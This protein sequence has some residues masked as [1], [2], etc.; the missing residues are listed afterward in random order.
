VIL[1]R[2]YQGRPEKIKTLTGEMIVDTHGWK[3]QYDWICNGD[4]VLVQ[5]V[6]D[7][8]RYPLEEVLGWMQ[9]IMA[10]TMDVRLP[11]IARPLPRW[12]RFC[13]ALHTHDAKRMEETGHPSHY[14]GYWFYNKW[15]VSKRMKCVMMAMMGFKPNE[16]PRV[17]LYDHPHRV[18]TPLLYFIT[19]MS[20]DKTMLFDA[21]LATVTS[22]RQQPLQI[23]CLHKMPECDVFY[24]LASIPPHLCMYGRWFEGRVWSVLPMGLNVMF[25]GVMDVIPVAMWRSFVGQVDCGIPDLIFNGRQW[26]FRLFRCPRNLQVWR[27]EP[28]IG[29]DYPDAVMGTLEGLEADYTV[30]RYYGPEHCDIL[31]LMEAWPVYQWRDKMMLIWWLMMRKT[32]QVDLTVQ[33]WR[34]MGVIIS[35]FVMRF[36]P[37]KCLPSLAPM[38]Q[39]EA[40]TDDMAIERDHAITYM[41]CEEV[42]A[43]KVVTAN[44]ALGWQMKAPKTGD[45]VRR[46]MPFAYHYVKGLGYDHIRADSRVEYVNEDHDKRIPW[47]T[48]KTAP[49]MC[50]IRDR[51][52]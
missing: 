21:T 38:Y 23:N 17:D 49:S 14:G 7:I 15:R 29:Q 28:R 52:M 45:V 47:V 25:P 3:A 32:H 39:R 19:A 30:P 42:K 12:V 20:G 6:S 35:P 48:P 27:D 4:L 8:T 16:V 41:Y 40:F 44:C 5:M 46:S 43:Y 34:E 1:F 50:W 37:V 24:L 18:H 51:K 9:T 10:L 31:E 33:L 22:I 11:G 2:P 36:K 26:M 13:L